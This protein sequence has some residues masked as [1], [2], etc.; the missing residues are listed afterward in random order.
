[1][2]TDAQ[3]RRLMSLIPK[4]ETLAVAAAKAGMHGREDG[5]Q[6][7]QIGSSAQRDE[8]RTHVADASGSVRRY[9][10]GSSVASGS[11]PGP[12]SQDAVRTPAAEVSGTVPGWPV[13]YAAAEDQDL[14][15]SGGSSPRGVLPAG[16]QAG[17]PASVEG[18]SAAPLSDVER[19]R[20]RSDLTL[21]DPIHSV[22]DGILHGSFGNW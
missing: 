14:A 16:P 12:G 8:D 1:M 6:V 21:D 11:Q 15:R 10:A 5:A 2:V 9:V 22:S 19:I 4:E 18:F 3:V 7:S 13:A 20:L 17:G